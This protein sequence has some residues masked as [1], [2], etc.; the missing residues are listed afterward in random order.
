MLENGLGWPD[1]DNQ[2]NKYLEVVKS[3]TD[4]G[5]NV[6]KIKGLEQTFPTTFQISSHT[7][8]GESIIRDKL[9]GLEEQ[10]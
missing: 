10:W 1:E 8:D 6:C 7:C 9:N 5:S 4:S 2:M 3:T